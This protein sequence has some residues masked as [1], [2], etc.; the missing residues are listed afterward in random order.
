MKHKSGPEPG[1]PRYSSRPFPAYRFLPG[2]S[3]HPRRNP[4][5]HSFGCPE[6]APAVVTVQNWQRS[7][8]YRYGVDLFN[9]GYW[10]EAH[11]VFEALWDAA[12][13]DTEAGQ[14]FQ[15]LVHVAGAN[16]KLEV[17]N[18]ASAVTLANNGLR[19]L[20]RLPPHYMGV[21][22]REL[23]ERL[24]RAITDVKAPRPALRLAVTSPPPTD[25]ERSG[26]R[27]YTGPGSPGTPPPR[28]HR[29]G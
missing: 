17:E 26:G 28:P 11:E 21:D 3:P 4:R 22:L 23:S 13:H 1:A 12:G 25:P 24:R 29:R 8:W 6:P 14:F 15:A 2:Q 18:L 19:R 16:L 20:A 27:P 10:W 7:D 5:G 9:Y